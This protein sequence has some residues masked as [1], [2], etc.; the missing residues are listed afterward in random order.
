MNYKQRIAGCTLFA[1]V[2]CMICPIDHWQ[3]AQCDIPEPVNT[4]E[5]VPDKDEL[6]P[7]FGYLPPES[8]YA[9]PLFHLRQDYPIAEPGED[10][11]PTFL[12][13]PFDQ[14]V[15]KK[16]NWKKYLLAVRD[17][18]FE[19]NIPVDWV[20]QKNTKRGWY[21]VPWQHWGRNGREGI[22]GL[23]REA[24]AQLKQLAPTQKDKFQTYAVGVYNEFGGY[25]I[26]QVWRDHNRPDS[27]KAKF[28]VGTVVCKLLFTQAAS[29]QVP[30]LENSL[31]WE[32]YSEISDVNQKRQVQKLRLLQMDVM[33]RDDRALRLNGTG[34]VFG[35]YCYNGTLANPDRW[36]NLVPVGLQWGNDPAVSDGEVNPK[37][38]RTIVNSDLKETV[39]NSSHELPPQHLG[40]GGRL[41]G[42]A[43][44]FAS[45]CMSCHSAAQYPVQAALNPEFKR[46]APPVR[47]SREWMRWFRN[48][49]CGEPFS[50][51]SQSTD[52]SLQ[53]AN[54]IKNFH[55][56][57][58]HQ[59]GIFAKPEES[60][61]AHKLREQEEVKRGKE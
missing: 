30:Y 42:P 8:Q 26:G 13:I 24:T 50:E 14:N 52:F 43:D 35:T 2:S 3:S 19:G 33:I 15:D 47:G 12:K 31:E 29:D 9:G 16:D 10:K 46:V 34:W 51:Q 41:N 32:A 54:G 1:L 21:H 57:Q 6:F 23:T 55:E 25:T 49:K 48:L 58:L 4:A 7:D 59:G 44:Y 37:A 22:H 5:T 11:L 45:S 56:W 18:C 27:K 17:Y 61:R 53:L 39:I 40:W 38:T 20:V 36:N 28:P 60:L